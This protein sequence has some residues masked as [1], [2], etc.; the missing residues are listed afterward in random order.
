MTRVELLAALKAATGPSRELDAW[1]ENIFGL[2]RWEEGPWVPGEGH[3][4][5]KRLEPK[6]FTDSIDAALGLVE[7]MLPGWVW[8]LHH[9]LTISFSMA[10]EDDIFCEPFVATALT[11]PLAILIA[12]LMAL[13]TNH[14]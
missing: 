10:R 5:A 14:G 8:A 6:P 4:Y 1:I 9:R 13:E 11:A 7:R 2:S 3:I 12:L